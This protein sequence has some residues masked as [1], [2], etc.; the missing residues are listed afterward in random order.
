MV[1]LTKGPI[2]NPSLLQLPA[3]P[4]SE[5]CWCLLDP[6]VAVED[7]ELICAVC[8]RTCCHLALSCCS[9]NCCRMGTIRADK[10]GI[11]QGSIMGSCIGESQLQAVWL[12]CEQVQEP[13][14]SERGVDADHRPYT[15]CYWTPDCSIIAPLAPM[16]GT[17]GSTAAVRGPKHNC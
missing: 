5:L 14:D 1:L 16:L 7:V 11:L 17:G 10:L 12:G 13:W 8:S 9:Q 3:R 2:N 15:Y 4:A 6:L